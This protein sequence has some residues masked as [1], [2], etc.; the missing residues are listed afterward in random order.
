MELFP[1]LLD[2][3]GIVI[4]GQIL[5]HALDDLDNIQIVLNV[6]QAGSTLTS[7]ATGGQRL[8]KLL[9]VHRLLQPVVDIE[10]L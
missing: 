7:A 4:V 3:A 10:G 5:R 8:L 1:G 6:Q 9:A 2:A